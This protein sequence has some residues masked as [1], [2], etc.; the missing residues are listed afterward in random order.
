MNDCVYF[1]EVPNS[2]EHICYLLKQCKLTGGNP[3][4]PSCD[5]CQRKLKLDDTDFPGKWEDPVIITT[6]DKERTHCLR[7]LLAGTPAFLVGGG[8]SAEENLDKLNR[9]GVFSLAINNAAGYI[10]RPQAFVCSDPPMKF[11]HSIWL[12]PGVMKFIPIPKLGG[13]RSKLRWKDNGE[14]K[15]LDKKSFQCPNVWGFQRESWLKPDDSFFLTNGVHW[16]N[17][18]AGVKRTG[19][20]KTVCTMLLGL[21]LMRYLGCSKLFLLGNDFY[22]GDGYGYSFGQ[23]RTPEACNSNNNQFVTVNRWLCQMQEAGVFERFGMPI[24][25]CFEKSGLRAFPY[26]PFDEALAE[27]HGIVEAVPDLKKWYEKK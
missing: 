12:D 15:P 20:E 13:G 26:T 1:E 22:M 11:S 6:R 9:R 4:I 25:N 7:N 18:K 23:G 21:R 19:E 16:G 10:V 14:F 27:C 3:S 5:E 8:P 24:Y 2:E 17:H